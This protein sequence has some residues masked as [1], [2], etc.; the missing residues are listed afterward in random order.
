MSD[1]T[2]KALAITQKLVE[3]AEDLLAP[4]DN[5]MRIMKWNPEFQKIMWD[6]VHLAVVNRMSK[7]P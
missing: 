5:E 4:L 7:L 1:H 6:A 2:T 3:K